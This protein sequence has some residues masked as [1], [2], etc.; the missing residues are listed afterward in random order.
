[1]KDIDDYNA[2]DYFQDFVESTTTATICLAMLT[3]IGVK[4]TYNKV[5]D[6]CKKHKTECKVDK[7]GVIEGEVVNEN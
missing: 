2:K 6:L 7:D 4:F 5:K 3:Y 1:M